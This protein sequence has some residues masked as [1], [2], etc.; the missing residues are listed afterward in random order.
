MLANTLTRMER[1][2]LIKRT[3]HPIDARAQQIWLTDREQEIK[4]DA[5]LAANDVNRSALVGLSDKESAA[6]LPRSGPSCAV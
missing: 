6:G 5:Y 1:D 4:K 3:K 2:A